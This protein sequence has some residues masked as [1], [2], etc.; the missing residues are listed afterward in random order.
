MVHEC[1]PHGPAALGWGC[2]TGEC[3]L[4]PCSP[5]EQLN[6]WATSGTARTE[7]RHERRIHARKEAAGSTGWLPGT[8]FRLPQTRTPH[9]PAPAAQSPAPKGGLTGG[10]GQEREGPGVRGGRCAR[11]GGGSGRGRGWVWAGARGGGS[12]RGRGWGPRASGPRTP[13]TVTAAPL[14]VPVRPRSPPDPRRPRR[15]RRQTRPQP[16]TSGAPQGPV[17]ARA[18]ELLRVRRRGQ[19]PQEQ[20][21]RPESPRLGRVEL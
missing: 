5:G 11:E 16:L 19:G 7:P 6:P 13:R 4:S 1:G 21:R 15:P 20:G 10:R 9:S 2:G 3:L 17:L 18:R 12:G 14:S 8:G